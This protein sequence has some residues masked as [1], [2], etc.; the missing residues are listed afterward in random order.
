MKKNYPKGGGK[1][2]VRYLADWYPK[3]HNQSEQHEGHVRTLAFLRTAKVDVT[4]QQG[5]EVIPAIAR[6]GAS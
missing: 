6:P 5:I 3:S 4:L 1:G 2:R